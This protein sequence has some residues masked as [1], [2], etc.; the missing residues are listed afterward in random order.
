MSFWEELYVSVLVSGTVWSGMSALALAFC[1][2]VEA[3]RP[4]WG[5][6]ASFAVSTLCA[7]WCFGRLL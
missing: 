2:R 7:A 5:W 1:V 6:A 4:A 3:G